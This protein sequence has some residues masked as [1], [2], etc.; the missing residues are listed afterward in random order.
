MSRIKPLDISSKT[1]LWGVVVLITGFLAAVLKWKDFYAFF[2][3][4]GIL[5]NWKFF[6]VVVLLFGIIVWYVMN[7]FWKSE[8]E[9]HQKTRFEKENYLNQLKLSENDRLSD[10][11]TGIPNSRSLEMDLEKYFTA[12]RTG[13]KVQFIL[14]DLKNFRMVN[15]KFGFIKANNLLRT[16]AQSIYKRMRRNE[17]MYKCP[18][19]E[20]E[21]KLTNERFYRVHTG[22]DEFAFIIEGDQSDALGFSNRL[23]GQFKALSGKTKDILGEEFALSFHCAIVEVDPRDTMADI[24]EKAGICYRIAIEG[25]ADFTL[26]WHPVNVEAGFRN[27][28]KKLMEYERARKLFEVLSFVDKKYY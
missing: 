10:V 16:I 2:V 22:G 3:P 23:V 21:T 14:I 7:Y 8:F 18:V 19:N 28:Q 12:V 9:A 4:N 27:D 25:K 1:G 20:V 13:S 6:I 5:L 26:C 17:D 11:I 15:K 24:M